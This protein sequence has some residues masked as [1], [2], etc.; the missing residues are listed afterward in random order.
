MLDRVEILLR[1]NMGFVLP[2]LFDVYDNSLGRKWLTAFNDIL[3]SNLHLEKNYCFFGFP[4]SPRDLDFLASEI[5]RT[6]A[7]INGSSIDYMIKDYFTPANMVE[8][9]YSERAGKDI[10]EV[11]H[12]KFNQLH[13][14]FEETQGV[15]GAM[16]KHYTAAD[17][18]TRWYIRQLNLLC[19]EAECLIISLS[20]KDDTPQWIRPSNVMCWLNAPRFVL[21]DEDYNLFGIDT[22]ARDYGG[23]YVGVN[24]AVGKHHYEVFCDEGGESRLDELTTTTLKPQTEAA[25][26]FD[27][28]WGRSTLKEP[29]MKNNLERFRTWLVANNFDPNDPSLTIGH[30][31]IGQVD[32]VS[33]FKSYDF[34]KVINTLSEHLDVYSI[35][36]SDAYCEYDY[37]WHDSKRLQVPLIT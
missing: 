36:T 21:D 31:K 35:K 1:N 26:D 18:E 23:V 37:T 25:G 32:F 15:S 10:I 30:P 33:S 3:D 19:H 34:A 7:G 20:R 4:K 14:Y 12:D 6:I 24:K 27:I 22:I 13:L 11:N 16:S 8:T 29:F 9:N 5:N 2:V 28:E 17:A